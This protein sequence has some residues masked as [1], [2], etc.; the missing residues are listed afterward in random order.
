MFR[1]TLIGRVVK[2]S[3]PRD[4]H[5][6]AP[7]K[8]FSSAKGP[9]QM[10]TKDDVVE[11]PSDGVVAPAKAGDITTHLADCAGSLPT[12]KLRSDSMKTMLETV[13]TLLWV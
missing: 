1:N 6:E 7:Q 12:F 3:D 11:G 13:A 4:K 9:S 10:L 5:D 2:F 8:I